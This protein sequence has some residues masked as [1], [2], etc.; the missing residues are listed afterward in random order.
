LENLTFIWWEKVVFEYLSELGTLLSNGFLMDEIVSLL[1]KNDYPINIDDF[2]LLNNV[3][4]YFELAKQG[5]NFYANRKY[6]KDNVEESLNAFINI[7]YVLVNYFDKSNIKET[8]FLN[9]LQRFEREIELIIKE[10]EI[11]QNKV[12]YSL[13]LFK[14]IGEK[15]LEESSKLMERN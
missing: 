14:Q 3:K 11:S 13:K 2:T 4:N 10:K 15:L 1:Q 7:V 6:P 12:E 5:Y 8:D 9:E